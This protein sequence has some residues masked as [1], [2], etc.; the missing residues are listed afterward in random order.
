[1]FVSCDCHIY[2]YM[3]MYAYVQVTVKHNQNIKQALK[4]AMQTRDLTTV[5]CVVYVIQKDRAKVLV[6]WSTPTAVLGGHEV[7]VC[8]WV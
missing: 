6:D 8:V 3:Y 4:K 2:L 5:Q 7:C 1:M